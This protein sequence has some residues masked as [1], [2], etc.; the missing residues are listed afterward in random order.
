MGL[1]PSPW[2][3]VGDGFVLSLEEPEGVFEGRIQGWLWGI[4]LASKIIVPTRRAGAGAV[5]PSAA[6]QGSRRFMADYLLEQESNFM[7]KQMQHA[8]R[9][10]SPRTAETGI[11]V[12][13]G[14]KTPRPPASPSVSGGGV[15][16]AADESFICLNL[17]ES[18]SRHNPL[19][20]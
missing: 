6:K 12:R 19:D 15:K 11:Q 18:V 13:W 20:L 1:G 14:K 10:A 2:E 8:N 3:L 17:A 7:S 5:I 9:T 16:A 4:V